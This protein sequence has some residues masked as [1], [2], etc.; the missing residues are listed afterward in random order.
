MFRAEFVAMKN[1]VETLRCLW[2]KLRM[3]GVTIEVPGYIYGDNISVIYNNS[4]PEYVLR[5][6]SDII[7][8]HF[9]R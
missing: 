8:Y 5:K 2:Y 7:C 4:R 1:G 9:A 6:K 3:M